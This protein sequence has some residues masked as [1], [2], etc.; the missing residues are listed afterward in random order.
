MSKL[1]RTRE[2]E[3]GV[4]TNSGIPNRAFALFAKSIGGNAWEL[5]GRIWF[6]TMVGL[7]KD[8]SFA[9]FAKRSLKQ[10]KHHGQAAE[11]AIESAWKIVGVL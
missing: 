8:S 11:K 5:P 9:T 1:V 4:H 6:D 10:A 3:G 7:P 2:D